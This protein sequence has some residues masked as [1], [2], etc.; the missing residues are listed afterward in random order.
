[1]SAASQSS[2]RPNAGPSSA[3]FRSI[4]TS[5]NVSNTHA[6]E[7]AAVDARIAEL[8]RQQQLLMEQEVERVKNKKLAE[9]QA[10]E[11]EAREKEARAK[12]KGKVTARTD[13]DERMA[14]DEGQASPSSSKRKRSPRAETTQ[15]RQRKRS[16]RAESE[17]EHCDNAAALGLLSERLGS[18]QQVL[19]VLVTAMGE[20]VGITHDLI[21]ASIAQFRRVAYALERIADAQERAHPV[22]VRTSGDHKEHDD[23]GEE[24][25]VV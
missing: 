19:T 23:G 24:E 6:E 13:D 8:T 22:D 25:S 7:I 16:R 4:S 2:N 3:Q 14:V 20:D 1:M 15:K 9:K 17:E 12:G 10:R 21:Q 18:F 11:M 5:G